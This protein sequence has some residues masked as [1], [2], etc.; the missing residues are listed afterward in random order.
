M[1]IIKKVF[2]KLWGEEV[3]LYELSNN[4]NVKVCITNYGGIVTNIY[5]PDKDNNVKDITLGFDSLS[6][7]LQD[8]PYFG[9]IVGRFANRINKGKF[10][11]DKKK[12]QLN[13]QADSNHLHGGLRGFDKHIWN[14]KIEQTSSS[15]S[16]VLTR[17][18]KDGEENYPGNLAVTA[19]YTLDNNN[20]LTLK[21]MAKSDKDTII[22]LVNHCYFNLAGH[23]SGSIQKSHKISINSDKIVEVNKNLIPIGNLKDITNTGLYCSELTSMDSIFSS[24]KDGV[25]DY[26][27][28]LNDHDGNVNS[29]AH[30]EEQNTGR[31]LEIFTD[32]VG[33]QFYNSSQLDIKVAKDSVS[34][35]K[36]QGFCLETQAFPDSPNHH[37]FPSCVLKAGE[38][39]QHTYKLK[40]GVL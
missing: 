5:T 39:Y 16:L 12:Y 24:Q 9:A 22:N 7:Y 19:T 28:V 4:N 38:K 13:T 30:V 36:F 32:N 25:V 17:L 37:N 1:N 21:F 40:F 8:S 18:S 14:A 35:S 29:V 31:T 11:L 34:Y 10:V 20:E 6:E 33:M 2:G 15:V 27:Y 26:C 23:D 3:Y